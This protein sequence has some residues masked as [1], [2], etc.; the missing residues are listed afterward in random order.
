MLDVGC[1][2]ATHIPR[3]AKAVGAASGS[4]VGVDVSTSVIEEAKRSHENTADNNV[5]FQ[6]ANVYDLPFDANSFHVV[7]EDRVLE[8]LVRPLEAVQEMLRVTKLGG[9]VVVANPD[10]RSFTMDCP[11]QRWGERQRP[12]PELDFDFYNAMTKLLNGVV[13]TLCAHPSV[14]LQMPR[15]L[16]AAGCQDVELQVVPLPLMGR[17]NLEKVVPISY[18]ARLSHHNGA[19]TQDEMTRTMDRLDWEGEDIVGAMNMYICRGVKPGLEQSTNM[20]L[21][22]IGHAFY[23]DKPQSPPKHD[24]HI[25]L[26]SPDYDAELIEQARNLVNN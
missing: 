14:G 4:V 15:L 26:A 10:F 19:I 7:K 3:Y 1:G 6:V 21:P 11:S 23:T 12:P 25:R 2:T 18:M 5:Q 17:E 20:S 13:P 16:R 8:H 24:V 9:R 22:T